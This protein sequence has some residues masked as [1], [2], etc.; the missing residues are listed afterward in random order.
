MRIWEFYSSPRSSSSEK[1]WGSFPDVIL[2]E[3]SLFAYKGHLN[4]FTNVDWGTNRAEIE[5]EG[6]YDIRNDRGVSQGSIYVKAG[7]T[8]F[9]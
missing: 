4:Q 8:V 5:M 1:V 7:C 2:L 9:W 6:N 3:P